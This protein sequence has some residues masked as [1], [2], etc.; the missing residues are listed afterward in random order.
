M[1][2]V[3]QIWLHPQTAFISD[4]DSLAQ[5]FLTTPDTIKWK[6]EAFNSSG[7]KTMKTQFKK[8]RYAASN[9]LQII[10]ITVSVVNKF[11]LMVTILNL[12]NYQF[13]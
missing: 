5:H 8:K 3:Y 6:L 1:T 11:Y 13:F 10:T 4:T 12:P 7:D 9:M 2:H